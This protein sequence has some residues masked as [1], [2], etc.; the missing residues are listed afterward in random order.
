M[1][2]SAD[3][4][5]NL[6]FSHGVPTL[7]RE[8]VAWIRTEPDLD[9]SFVVVSALLNC[10]IPVLVNKDDCVMSFCD[11]IC[12]HSIAGSW[13]FCDDLGLVDAVTL[14]PPGLAE[15][16]DDGRQVGMATVPPLD[17]FLKFRI[18]PLGSFAA[19]VEADNG[20]EGV[21]ETVEGIDECDHVFIGGWFFGE[22]S[23]LPPVGS[24]G[25]REPSSR[26]SFDISTGVFSASA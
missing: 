20:A 25:R 3:S 26:Y 1:V 15:R 4:G 14:A 22:D 11:L 9:D 17:A 23:L 16:L 19:A 10:D 18:C 24:G 13:L 6:C 12:V 7:H 2:V 8:V 21:R 5:S